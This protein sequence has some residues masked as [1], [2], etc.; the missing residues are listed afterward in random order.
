ML[1]REERVLELFEVPA[2]FRSQL[3]WRQRIDLLQL[4]L[5]VDGPY[6]RPALPLR[7]ERAEDVSHS[8]PLQNS[9]FKAPLGPQGSIQ[10]FISGDRVAALVREF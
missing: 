9:R 6:Q 2:E 1:R 4:R 5:V 10:I 7:K 3:V 8:I